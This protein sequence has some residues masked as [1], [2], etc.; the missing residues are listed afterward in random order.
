M[1]EKVII[2]G[3]GQAGAQGA[4][5]LRQAG[6]EGD[7]LLLGAE[8]SPPY[9]RPPLSKA[10]LKGELD[11]ERLLL[12]PVEFYRTQNIEFKPGVRATRIDPHTRVVFT[13]EGGDYSS[14]KLLIAT[15]APPR[16]LVAPGVDLAGVYYL[17]SL[18]DSD[19][20]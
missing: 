13:D 7:I 2:I 15:G 18:V 19:A 11:Q 8:P 10:Y 3:A 6:F 16:R 20:L 14:D 4:I 9:Q 12:R 5:S 17:R 1:S